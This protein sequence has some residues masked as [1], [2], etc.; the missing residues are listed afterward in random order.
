MGETITAG[1]SFSGS[2]SE[3][4]GV[5][6]EDTVV[7]GVVPRLSVIAVHLRGIAQR[8]LAQSKRQY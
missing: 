2:K 5:V 8:A 6:N 4:L 1:G 3:A 7:A